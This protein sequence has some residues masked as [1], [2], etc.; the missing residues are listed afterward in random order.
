VWGGEG[1]GGSDAGCGK[2]IFDCKQ[3][4]L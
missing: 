1:G 2:K 3:G 4:K